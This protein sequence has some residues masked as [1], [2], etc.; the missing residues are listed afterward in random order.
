[1]S[2]LSQQIPFS[3]VRTASSQSRPAALECKPQAIIQAMRDRRSFPWAGAKIDQE[4]QCLLEERHKVVYNSL[5][6]ERKNSIGW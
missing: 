6:S 3:P 5:A 2:T 1:M 4:I